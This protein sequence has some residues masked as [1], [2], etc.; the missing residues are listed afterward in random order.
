MDCYLFDMH[1]YN[2]LKDGFFSCGRSPT[3]ILHLHSGNLIIHVGI[4]EKGILYAYPDSHT[5]D[6]PRFTIARF[7]K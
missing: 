3:S 2:E 4:L 6:N 5:R 7:Y 1:E